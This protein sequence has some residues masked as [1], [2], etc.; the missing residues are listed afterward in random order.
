MARH[1]VAFEDVEKAVA[2]LRVKGLRVTQL[3]VLNLLGTGSLSTIHKHL[4]VINDR[5]L[6]T[7]S[8]TKALPPEIESVLKE[9]MTQVWT[10]AS[11]LA[12]QDIEAIRAHARER[13]ERAEIEVTEITEAFDAVSAKLAACQTQ[14]AQMQAEVH[15]VQSERA[16]AK[17][18]REV[19][20]KQIELLMAG[21]KPAR[22]GK[23]KAA[24]RP[25]AN[26]PPKVTKPLGN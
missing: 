20:E 18:Q 12:S 5:E 9:T 11:S 22:S 16:V 8:M 26:T 21:L 19:L 23:A 13:T 6:T 2:E 1:G 10:Q 25:S 4:K 15:Q 17:G 7:S 24:Q 14:I 3:A